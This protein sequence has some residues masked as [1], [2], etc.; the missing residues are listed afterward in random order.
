[1][2]YVEKYGTGGEV[3]DY[4]VSITGRMRFACRI[5]EAIIQ[6]YIHNI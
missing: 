3:T 5:T 6:T 2:I 4:I 1:M